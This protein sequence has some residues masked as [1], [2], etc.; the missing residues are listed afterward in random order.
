MSKRGL[1]GSAVDVVGSSN[2]GMFPFRLRA[3]IDICGEKERRG[4]DK[5]SPSRVAAKLVYF[6]Q[7]L[8][9]DAPFSAETRWVRP[10]S[11]FTALLEE[12]EE[13]NLAQTRHPMCSSGQSS[14]ESK[15]W[16]RYGAIF[17]RK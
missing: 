1:R 14:C 16:L 17:K 4:N 9:F 12:E 15:S 5:N 2:T 8:R 11:L 13:Q 6:V 10:W 3:V 7:A